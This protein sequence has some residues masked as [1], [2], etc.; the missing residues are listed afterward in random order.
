MNQEEPQRNLALDLVRV[1]EAAALASSRWLGKGDNKKGDMAAVD[2]MRLSFN[3]IE[4]KGVVV[5]GEG[6]KDKAPMLYNGESL[7]T[8]NGPGMDV[9]VDPVEGTKLLAYGRPNAISVVALAPRGTMYD[10]GP[11]FYM[12]KIAVPSQARDH[13]DINAPVKDNLRAIAASLGKSVD[14]LVVFVLDKPRHKQLIEDIRQ[15]GARIQLHT[16][17]DVA[18]ALMAVSPDGDVDVMMGTGGTPEGVLTAA[19]IISMG[20]EMQCR[21]DPQSEQEKENLLS[22]GYDLK[23][24]LTVRDLIQSEDVFFAATGISGGTFLQGVSFTGQGALTRSMV[25]RGK[26]GTLRRIE[27]LHSFEKLMRIS[28]IKYK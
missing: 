1:T 13:V 16:D 19:A 8:G 6:E 5:I 22:A 11:A 4:I 15:A 28:A 18:G 27:S 12:Q 24:V 21:L 26:T 10:P 17:G 9:A 7:G 14:D 25:M 3:A 23:R 20:G 2:A